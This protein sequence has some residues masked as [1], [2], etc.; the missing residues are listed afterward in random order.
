VQ[1]MATK[2]AR[3]CGIWDAARAAQGEKA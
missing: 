2:Y 3:L 1:D